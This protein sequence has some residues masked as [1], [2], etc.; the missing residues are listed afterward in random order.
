MGDLFLVV[1]ENNL[2]VHIGYILSES[3]IEFLMATLSPVLTQMYDYT[4]ILRTDF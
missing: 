3:H 4:L 1:V 2:S